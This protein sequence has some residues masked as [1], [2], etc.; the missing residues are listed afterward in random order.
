[1]RLEQGAA[2]DPIPEFRQSGYLDAKIQE[3]PAD[4]T[5]KAGWGL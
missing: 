2:A 3:R 5:V 1:V 4:Q